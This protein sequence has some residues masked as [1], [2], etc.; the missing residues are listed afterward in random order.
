MSAVTTPMPTAPSV[1]TG[2]QP[3]RWTVEQYRRLGELGLF[4]DVKP[5]LI[6]GE[7]YTMVM[8]SPP[9]DTA[10]GL[11]EEWLRS[12]FVSGY[13]VRSQKGFDIGTRH[14]PGPDLAVV[15]GSIRDYATR[16]PTTAALVVEVSDTSLFLDTTTK[17]ELYATAQIPEYWVLDLVNRQLVVS[18][19]PA[20]LP[21][22]LGA[23]AYRTRLTFGPA[24]S[25]EP[26][27]APGHPVRV[28][29]LLP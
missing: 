25:V 26:L 21:A 13:H 29:D 11:T 2:P 10:L 20:P 16:T 6:D 8:P 28:A 24:D 9:H 18:R 14:D 17:A 15:P 27:A 1:A 19:D 4:H 23:T 7:I 22:G 5:M 12:V 3:F